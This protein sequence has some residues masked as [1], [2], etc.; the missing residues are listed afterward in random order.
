MLKLLQ[1]R[2]LHDELPGEEHAFIVV[3][4]GEEHALIVV[5]TGEEHALVVAMQRDVEHSRIGVEDLLRAVAMVNVPVHDQYALHAVGK[6]LLGGYG[7]VIEVA[8]TPGNQSTK[9]SLW[10]LKN[11]HKLHQ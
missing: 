10:K 9:Q 4:T 5:L 8:E 6:Q 1:R 3:L 7:D 11:L 2:E